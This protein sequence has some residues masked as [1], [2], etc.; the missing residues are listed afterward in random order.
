MVT[1]SPFPWNCS[2]MV[3]SCISGLTGTV[4]E[5][6]FSAF[7]HLFF[8]YCAYLTR[9]T[10][11][12]S[13]RMAAAAA[14]THFGGSFLIF[15]VLRSDRFACFSFI[16]G[17]PSF[18][19]RC[20][21]FSEQALFFSRAVR[22]CVNEKARG[23]SRALKNAPLRLPRR[24]FSHPKE[25]KTKK[26]CT[27]TEREICTPGVDMNLRRSFILPQLSENEKPLFPRNEKSVLPGGENAFCFGKLSP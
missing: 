19:R 4:I 5:G 9:P 26:K 7:S 12:H 10:N 21:L 6:L 16:S 24:K 20:A 23:Q 18:S 3:A 1:N 25:C 22:F 13:K 15:C 27:F 14:I 17:S 11:A 2:C 8:Q